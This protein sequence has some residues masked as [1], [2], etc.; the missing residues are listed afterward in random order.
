[1]RELFL[2]RTT[3]VLRGA[4]TKREIIDTVWGEKA[5]G[6]ESM[7][8]YNK[9]HDMD[10]FVPEACLGLKGLSTGYYS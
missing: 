4:V 3:E 10:T 6:N 7:G 2:C 9:R 5:G 1:M 8:G